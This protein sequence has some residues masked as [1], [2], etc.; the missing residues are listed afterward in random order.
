MAEDH[1][2]ENVAY[3]PSVKIRT[4]SAGQ[5]FLGATRLVAKLARLS[6][7]DYERD[8]LAAAKE[9]GCRVSFLDSHV[10]EVRCRIESF[11][12]R[13][14]G[15]EE[16]NEIINVQTKSGVVMTGWAL[17]I[18]YK[19]KFQDDNHGERSYLVLMADGSFS[20]LETVPLD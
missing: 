15:S 1:S 8:R 3:L 11:S 10:A 20:L 6:L 18:G 5:D 2:K 14:P 17:A 12:Y 7:L 4:G 19:K 9:L 13:V 16:R